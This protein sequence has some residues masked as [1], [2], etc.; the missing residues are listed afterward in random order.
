MCLKD[1]F[2]TISKRQK[3]LASFT[4]ALRVLQTIVYKKRRKTLCR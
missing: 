1:T 3:K 2:L 4:K